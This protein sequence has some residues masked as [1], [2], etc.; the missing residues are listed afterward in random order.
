MNQPGILLTMGEYCIRRFQAEDVDAL[1]RYANNRS[2]SINLR[3]IFPYPYERRHAEAWLR[4]VRN[5]SPET[6]FAIATDEELIGGII[7]HPQS[8]V[9]RRSAELGY[10]LAEPY[11][12]RGIAT[13]AVQAMTEWGFGHLDINRIYAHVFGWNPASARVL[14]KAGY[15]L[16]GRLRQAVTK[17]GQVTDLLVYGMVR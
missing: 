8:D 13:R 17:D 1:V 14:E 11:W 16:E 9:H 12:G 5:M 3:D 2:V 6:S 15:V 10:W 7:L 4:D